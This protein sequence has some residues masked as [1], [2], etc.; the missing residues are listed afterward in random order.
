MFLVHLKLR[1]TH[2]KKYFNNLRTEGVQLY[3]KEETFSKKMD[4]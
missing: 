4:T 3:T 2:P 1:A